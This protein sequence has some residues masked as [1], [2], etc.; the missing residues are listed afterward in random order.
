MRVLV[1]T[2]VWAD[3]FNDADTRE[4]RVLARLIEDEIELVT[5]G[6]IIAELFQGLRKTRYLSELERQFRE[7]ECLTPREPDTYF[8]AAELYRSLRRRGIT[9][10]STIDCLIA[11]LA[12]EN[13]ALVL[14][15][16]KDLAAIL[17]SSASNA[18]AV[19]I[20]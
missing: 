15:R 14:A 9:I 3:F 6:V 4:A 11:R 19:P 8:A 18:R 17:D 16:D 10:R 13:D 20:Q 7:M 12:E 2:S 5:C 1:D